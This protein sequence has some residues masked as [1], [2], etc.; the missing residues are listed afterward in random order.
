MAFLEYSNIGIKGLAGAVPKNIINNYEYTLFFPEEEVK[1][2]V[3]KV[4][5]KERRFADKDTCASA[6]SCFAAANKL[7]SRI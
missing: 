7:F 1:K 2:I 6:T 5:I 4:G 3:D